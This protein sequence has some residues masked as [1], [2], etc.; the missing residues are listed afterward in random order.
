GT[1]APRITSV[2][3][4]LL[5]AVVAHPIDRR[6]GGVGVGGA[7]L[8]TRDVDPRAAAT[9]HLTGHQL[10]AL[11]HL[12]ALIRGDRELTAR[13]LLAQTDRIL[14]ASGQEVLQLR[15]GLV[16]PGPVA[17]R[18]TAR[19]LAIGVVTD[20]LEAAVAHPPGRLREL[21][22]VL[23]PVEGRPRA[24]LAVALPHPGVGAAVDLARDL[25]RLEVAEP[26]EAA[27]AQLL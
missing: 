26:R 19:D 11:G 10:G 1:D 12:H 2:D 23:L 3:T 6:L 9:G 15:A 21:G 14:R 24:Q 5:A 20:E 25:D 22:D 17:A 7:Q 4:P 27:L 18:P 8:H 16:H 13:A